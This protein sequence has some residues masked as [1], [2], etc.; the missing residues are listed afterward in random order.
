MPLSF[1]LP[2]RAIYLYR[3]SIFS[4]THSMFFET[5]R[6]R[7]GRAFKHSEKVLVVFFLFL[8][9]ARVFEFLHARS[10]GRS[11]NRLSIVIQTIKTTI[12]I[13]IQKDI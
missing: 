13:H 5:P 4:A 8:F 2:A 10:E 7:H 1:Y 9:C 11:A 12:I 3:L 6:L